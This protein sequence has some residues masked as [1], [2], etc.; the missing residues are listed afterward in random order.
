ME[1][2]GAQRHADLTNVATIH[3]ALSTNES[4]SLT[5]RLVRKLLKYW[6]AVRLTRVNTNYP[7][8][9]ILLE[10]LNFIGNK[11][12]NRLTYF[13]ENLCQIPKPE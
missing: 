7:K 9:S 13:Y 11:Y 2:T 12:F 8:S 3:Y 6:E 1:N 5:T 10:S 4:Y